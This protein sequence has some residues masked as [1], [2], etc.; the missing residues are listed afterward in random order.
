MWLWTKYP[1]STP[2]ETCKYLCSYVVMVIMTMSP[3]RIKVTYSNK[4]FVCFFYR[5]S[6]C[7]EN[8]NLIHVDGTT[9]YAQTY[10]LSLF[11][12]C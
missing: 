9:I 7:T 1:F 8:S 6:N 11:A 10:S 12:N 5:W 2:K 3:T 4:Y